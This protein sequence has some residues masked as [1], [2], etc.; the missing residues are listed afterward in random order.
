MANTVRGVMT[1][2]P[3]RCQTNA[4]V[5]EAAQLMRDNDIGDVVVVDAADIAGI[6]TDRDIVVRLVAE[7]LDAASTEV[8]EI[9]SEEVVTVSPD[10]EIDTAVRLMREHAVRRL[11]VLEAGAVVGIVSLGDLAVERDEGSV[12]AEISEAPPDE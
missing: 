5:L 6:L 8:S 4:P 2:A 11:P 1:A 10:E 12:L 9:C 7:G 3:L